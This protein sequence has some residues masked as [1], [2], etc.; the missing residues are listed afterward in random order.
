MKIRAN[1]SIEIAICCIYGTFFFYRNQKFAFRTEDELPIALLFCINFI[2][3]PIMSIALRS[4]D[5]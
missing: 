5:I 4:I 2:F 1:K 3:F